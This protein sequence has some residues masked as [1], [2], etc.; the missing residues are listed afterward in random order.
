MRDQRKLAAAVLV[1]IA[2]VAL[3]VGVIYLT[4]EAKSL[5]SFMG[6][7]H[8]ATGKRSHRGI[9]ALV[10]AGVLLVAGIGLLTARRQRVD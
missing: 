5:P 1:L 2:I 8:G 3:V 6:Q 7:V 10:V 4:T 9:A